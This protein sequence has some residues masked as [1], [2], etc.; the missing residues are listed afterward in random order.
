[1][2]SLQALNLIVLNRLKRRQRVSNG[3]PASIR[4]LSMEK[5]YTATPQKTVDENVDASTMGVHLGDQALLDL[6]DRENDEVSVCTQVKWLVLIMR[7]LCMSTRCVE[8]FV[9][10]VYL[11]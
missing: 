7:S 11:Y 3:K 9:L 10:Y 8:C 4:D 1:V 2:S 5:K 6:T